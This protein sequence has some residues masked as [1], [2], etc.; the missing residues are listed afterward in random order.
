MISEKGFGEVYEQP[1]KEVAYENQFTFP[2][3]R[4]HQEFHRIRSLK[5]GRPRFPKE[6]WQEVFDLTA[7]YSVAEIAVALAISLLSTSGNASIRDQKS[8]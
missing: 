3:R 5:Q 6:L 4:L 2:C 8:R 1:T 7:A